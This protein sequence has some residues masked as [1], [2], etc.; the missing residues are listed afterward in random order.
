MGVG[1]YYPG[2]SLCFEKEDGKDPRNFK[3]SFPIPQSKDNNGAGG[4]TEPYFTW[5]EMFFDFQRC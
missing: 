2:Q 3:R 4:D 1:Y 5:A